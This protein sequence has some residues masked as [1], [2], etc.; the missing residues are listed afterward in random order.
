MLKSRKMKDIHLKEVSL[1]DSPANLRPFLMFKREGKP[2]DGSLS[3]MKTNVN[4]EIESDGS[5]GGTSIIVNGDTIDNLQ[6]FSFSIW[7][8]SDNEASVNCSY[9]KLVESVD[10]FSRTETFYLTKGDNVMDPRIAKLIKSLFGDKEVKFE[11]SELNEATIVELEKALTTINEFKEEYPVELAKAIGL[12]SVHASQGY[13][14]PVEKKVEDKPEQVELAK[15]IKEAEDALAILKGEKSADKDE[16][17]ELQKTVEALNKSM[18]DITA[19]L[20]QK[21]ASDQVTEIGKMLEKVSDRLKVIEGQPA[22]KKKSL[23]NTPDSTTKEVQKDS[24]GR[25]IGQWPSLVGS[26]G[27]E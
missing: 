5:K 8:G 16:P 7:D 17:T 3:V 25:E 2:G 10:G 11:K 26:D 23:D 14:Q 6:S 13:A 27:D 12:V 19:K 22:T 15:K 20:E 1:V 9:S 21:E 18:A 4:I 24:E